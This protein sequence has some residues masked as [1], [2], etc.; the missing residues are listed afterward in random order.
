MLHTNRQRQLFA[1]TLAVNFCFL[2]ATSLAYPAV[3]FGK[4]FLTAKA[5]KTSS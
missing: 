5:P 4:F 3:A 2:S 1:V